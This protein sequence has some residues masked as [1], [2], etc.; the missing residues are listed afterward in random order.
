MEVIW[1]NS[2]EDIAI[3]RTEI[4][5]SLRIRFLKKCYIFK[6]CKDLLSKEEKSNLRRLPLEKINVYNV[7]HTV[8]HISV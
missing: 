8:C 6:S 5:E 2:S 3:E 1:I 4:A 7:Y